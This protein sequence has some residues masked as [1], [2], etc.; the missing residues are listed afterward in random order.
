MPIT[1]LTADETTNLKRLAHALLCMGFDR[2]ADAIYDA[3]GI[4]EMS[5]LSS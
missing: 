3:I 5:N 2:E 1:A 4:H